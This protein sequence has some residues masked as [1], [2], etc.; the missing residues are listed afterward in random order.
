MK[1]SLKTKVIDWATQRNIF[2]HSSALAQF[3]VFEEEVN[4][5][6]Q[7]FHTFQTLQTQNRNDKPSIDAKTHAYNELVDAFGDVIVTMINTGHFL[8]ID[9]DDAL[10]HAYKEISKR[11]EGAINPKTG[12]WDKNL[13][14]LASSHEPNE[15]EGM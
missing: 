15:A 2:T 1:K 13:R 12:K 11:T 9:I 8:K 6:K 3:R 14:P 10:H 4:E 7:W 5:L